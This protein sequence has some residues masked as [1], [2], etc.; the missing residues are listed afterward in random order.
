[1]STDLPV[2]SSGNGGIV[3]KPPAGD[4][5][6]VPGILNFSNDD[7]NAYK[8]CKKIIRINKINKILLINFIFYILNIKNFS[9]IY[10]I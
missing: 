1:L 2:V 5:V 9:L 4:Y 3:K 7:N 6:K 10:V 8:V